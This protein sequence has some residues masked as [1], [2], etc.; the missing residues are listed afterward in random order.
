MGRGER[1]AR[2]GVVAS[3]VQA[4]RRLGGFPDVLSRAVAGVDEVLLGQLGN[5][6]PI[7]VE[8]VGLPDGL[9]IPLQL[10]RREV[11]GLCAVVLVSH[12]SGHEVFEPQ[13]EVSAAVPGKEPCRQRGAQV[14][15][16][17]PPR[18]TRRKS[19]RTHTPEPTRV[20]QTPGL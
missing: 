20:C 11:V 5:G 12:R 2:A 7:E 9:V 19:P 14:A 1:A 18:R 3:S 13:E 4:V 16:M 6:L 17:Q 15:Q 10:E 8:P